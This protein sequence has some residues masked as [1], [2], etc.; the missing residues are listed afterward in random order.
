MELDIALDLFNSL[1]QSQTIR[2]VDVEHG[3]IGNATRY[4][5]LGRRRKLVLGKSLRTCASSPPLPD[6][7]GS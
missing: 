2:E 1:N 7:L 4:S 6:G 5:S 3:K